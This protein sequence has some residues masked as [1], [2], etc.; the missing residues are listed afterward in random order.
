ME[1]TGLRDV[2]KCITLSIAAMED[3]GLLPKPTNDPPVHRPTVAETLGLHHIPPDHLHVSDASRKSDMDRDGPSKKRSHSMITAE[4]QMIPQFPVQSP[5]PLGTDTTLLNTAAK[6]GSSNLDKAGASR[7][8]PKAK[9]AD[10]TKWKQN[11]QKQLRMEGK[12]YLSKRKKDGEIVTKQPRAVGPRCTSNACK[13]ASNRLCNEINE[14]TRKKVFD[15]FW[16]HMNWAQRKLYVAGQV[17]RDP[18]ERSRAVGSQSRRSVSLRYHLMVDGKRKQVCKNMFLST[19]GIGEWS[20]LNWAQRGTTKKAEANEN[21]L[22]KRPTVAQCSRQNP[23]P[24]AISHTVDVNQE[25]VNAT[26]KDKNRA[27]EPEASARKKSRVAKP[28]TWKQNR[29]KQLRME[30]KPYIS[31]RKKDGTTVT[32]AQRTIGPRCT[33]SACKRA[34]NRFCADFNEEARHDLFTTFWQCMNW[35]QRKIYVAGLVDCDPVERTRAPWTQSRRS[36]SMRYHLIADGDRKQVCKKMFLSTLGVG[37]WSVLNWAQNASQQGD[38]EE[39][40][41]KQTQR[42]SR[43]ASE[44]IVLK[45]FLESL[46]KV[47]SYCCGTSISKLYLEPVFSN[48]SDV[49]RHYYN[50]CLER[51]TTPLSRQVFCAV[52]KKMDLGLCDPKRDQSCTFGATGNLF[53]ELW[54]EYCMERGASG[55]QLEKAGNQ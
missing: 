21:K 18:V 6:N 25:Q 10:P 11:K 19:L 40:T 48:M 24:S 7:K 52:F 39:N 16:Q 29:Q 1:P 55:P 22:E 8:T 4:P 35:S 51:K 42:K 44:H 13:K 9:I 3:I 17:D 14:E 31:K 15:E 41:K 54:E 34:S 37:E 27:S 33:S 20:V 36:V 45:E 49:Y 50:H 30:G 47:P 5:L 43:K 46:P 23:P 38:S 32:K 12:E 26:D 28:L 53:N 2:F